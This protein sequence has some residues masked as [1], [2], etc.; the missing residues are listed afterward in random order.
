MKGFIVQVIGTS[1]NTDVIMMC[2]FCLELFSFFCIL[3]KIKG[4]I[5][6]EY[7]GGSSVS[8]SG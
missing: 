5:I 7:G 8:I 6:T 1:Q 2:N 3:N 4:K